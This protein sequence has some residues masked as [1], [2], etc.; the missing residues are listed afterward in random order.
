LIDEI[1]EIR[2]IVGIMKIAGITDAPA[3]DIKSNFDVNAVIKKPKKI[4][5]TVANR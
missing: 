3:L 2:A 4:I 5:Y 1:I